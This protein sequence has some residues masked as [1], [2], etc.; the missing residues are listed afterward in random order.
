MLDFLNLC[1]VVDPAKRATAE[2]L[3]QHPFLKTAALQEQIPPLIKLADELSSAE[4]F[5]DF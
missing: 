1:M 4:E 5:N 3:L 2:S